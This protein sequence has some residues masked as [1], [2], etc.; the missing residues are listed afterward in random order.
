M[1][2]EQLLVSES[3]A[4]QVTHEQEP[5]GGVRRLRVVD[6]RRPAPAHLPTLGA[7][8]LG[9]DAALAKPETIRPMGLHDGSSTGTDSVSERQTLGTGTLTDRQCCCVLTYALG[10]CQGSC[11]V[12]HYL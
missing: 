3:L 1:S 8:E 6:Q 7:R 11:A 5:L 2:A 10:P 4:A 9:L 12:Y